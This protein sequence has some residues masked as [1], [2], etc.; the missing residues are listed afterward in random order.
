[1]T[2]RTQK[3]L[4]LLEKQ[5]P[6]AV[7]DGHP[8]P[9]PGP[10]EI[11]VKV[12]AAALNP[13]DWKIAKTG[14][15]V[16]NYP[17]VLG[18]D[19]SGD[20]EDIGEGVVGL[21]KG[22]RVMAS[23]F[24]PK[25]YAAFQQYTLVAANLVT[26]LPSDLDYADAATIPL[27]YSTAAVGLLAAFPGGAGLNPTLDPA[28]KFSGQ[29]AFVLGGSSSVGQFAIQ[30]LRTLAFSPIITYASA[31]HANY[32][33]S[34]GAT[35]VIDRGTIIIEDI[36]AAVQN[37]LPPGTQLQVVYDAISEPDTQE[38]CWALV[39]EDG[40]VVAIQRGVADR[41]VGGK[42][43]IHIAGSPYAPI[44][45]DFGPRLWRMLTGQVEE[46]TIVPN[47]VE[48][49]PGGLAGIVD[50]LKRMENNAVSGVKLV[51]F[52]QET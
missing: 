52:P 22:D 32:L 33:K 14:D 10:G 26:K 37:L 28:I 23:A 5:G 2:M 20:V 48:K 15:F 1:M 51:V 36:P 49:L 11:L 18:W 42:R 13:V 21:E 29:P 16:Q 17:A 25:G 7:V 45:K 6:L 24:I 47:R 41:D 44:N 50:G 27:G 31:R 12:Q 30:I 34:L 39:S 3:A 35:H 9:N 40:I 43:L 46:G 8:I 38:V 19:L 4:L